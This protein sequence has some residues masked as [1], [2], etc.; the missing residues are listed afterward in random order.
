VPYAAK[1]FCGHAGCKNVIKDPSQGYCDFHR[2]E[3]TQ[4]YDRERT[5]EDERHFYVSSQ[6]KEARNAYLD[7]HPFCERC[8]EEKRITPAVIVH[9]K[10]SVKEF[11][12]LALEP[13]NFESV[14]RTCHNREHPDKGGKHD[15]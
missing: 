6:W 1:H 4:R 9:H 8:L 14:C 13:S 15:G 2:H 3:V 10:S 12:G 7:E 5:D 11:P